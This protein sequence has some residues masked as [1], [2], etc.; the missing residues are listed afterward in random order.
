MCNIIIIRYGQ[1]MRHLRKS[2]RRLQ[3]PQPTRHLTLQPRSQ[4]QSAI[5]TNLQLPTTRQIK[6]TLVNIHPLSRPSLSKQDE[7]Y[8]NQI[9][10]HEGKSSVKAL[11]TREEQPVEEVRFKNGVVYKGEW[12]GNVRHGYGVQVWPDGARYEGYWENGKATG[13]GKFTHVD[14]D[15]YDGEWR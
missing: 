3:S 1:R 9:V 5:S 7:D 6:S 12:K 13:R 4:K 11:Q 8:F 10:V 15:I 14:G 2:R